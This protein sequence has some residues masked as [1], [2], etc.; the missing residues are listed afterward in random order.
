ML[1][2]YNHTKVFR[3]MI[4]SNR[5]SRIKWMY[6]EKASYDVIPPAAHNGCK[7]F[8]SSRKSGCLEP[9]PID[10]EMLP[11]RI[12]PI[13]DP[14]IEFQRPSVKSHEWV[15]REGNNIGRL[16]EPG[17]LPNL[18]VVS[19][20]GGRATMAKWEDEWWVVYGV[21]HKYRK[22]ND[23]ERRQRIGRNKGGGT[24][25]FFD[26]KIKTEIIYVLHNVLD[27]EWCRAIKWIDRFEKDFVRLLAGAIDGSVRTIKK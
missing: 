18:L 24:G 11:L 4:A 1:K 7:D 15:A 6:A 23:H 10:C 21:K 14:I 9:Y 27:K 25:L 13:N 8:A 26:G 17:F 16:C 20:T 19:G 3:P 12:L 5:A 22:P 2:A